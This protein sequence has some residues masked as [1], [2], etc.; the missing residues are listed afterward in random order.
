MQSQVWGLRNTVEK[1]MTQ[2]HV[3]AMGSC[4]QRH[5]AILAPEVMYDKFIPAGI[6]ILN[7]FTLCLLLNI[8]EVKIPSD[9]FTICSH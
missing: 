2:R 6:C 3:L 5:V 4:S 7:T 1:E 9:L 8:L